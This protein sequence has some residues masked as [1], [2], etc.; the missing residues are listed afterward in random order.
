MIPPAPIQ[1][2]TFNSAVWNEWFR[3]MRDQANSSATTVPWSIINFTGSNITSIATR[4]HNDLTTKQ[5]G[6]VGEYYDL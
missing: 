4:D 6:S 1:N 5:G 2:K 3:Q